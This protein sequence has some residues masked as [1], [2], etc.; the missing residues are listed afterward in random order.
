VYSV[1]K[2]YE[3]TAKRLG[4]FEARGESLGPITRPTEFPTIS[5]E[6]YEK[7]WESV[8]PRDIDE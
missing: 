7:Y 8:D 5:S 6:D 2:S 3:L 4:E 1:N